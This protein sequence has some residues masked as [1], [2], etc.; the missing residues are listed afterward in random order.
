M[1]WEEKTS[2]KRPLSF[3]DDSYEWDSIRDDVPVDMGWNSMK[4]EAYKCE[5]GDG[6]LLPANDYSIEWVPSG[7]KAGGRRNAKRRKLDVTVAPPVQKPKSEFTCEFLDDGDKEVAASI[8]ELVT[9]SPGAFEFER[10]SDEKYARL[11]PFPPGVADDRSARGDWRLDPADCKLESLLS[12]T[13]SKKCRD[14]S[15]PKWGPA[16]QKKPKFEMM[17]V[18]RG[19]RVEDFS[20]KEGE[21]SWSTMESLVK[22][23]FTAMEPDARHSFA[24]RV[25]EML[26]E[27]PPAATSG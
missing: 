22:D 11:L 9:S 5:D 8:I 3:S 10:A 17:H 19:G 7:Y 20:I 15:F 4:V 27:K 14:I 16:Q 21:F 24:K 1:Q 23:Q 12:E 13:S 18:D 26:N 2:M 25:A 6:L